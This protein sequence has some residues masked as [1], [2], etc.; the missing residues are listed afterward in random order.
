[1]RANRE[2]VLTLLIAGAGLAL[3]WWLIGPTP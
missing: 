3:T 1:M 2:L